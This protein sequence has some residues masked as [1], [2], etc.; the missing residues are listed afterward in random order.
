MHFT[1]GGPWGGTPVF[2]RHRGR[3][4]N[5]RTAQTAAR[6]IESK[7]HNT[8]TDSRKAIKRFTYMAIVRRIP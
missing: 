4:R 5:F 6:Q 2:A 1:G 8:H 3:A 7:K